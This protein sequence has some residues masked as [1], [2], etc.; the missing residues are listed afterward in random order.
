MRVAYV[1]NAVYPEITGRIE[2]RVWELAG[3]LLHGG[4]RYTYLECSFGTGIRPLSGKGFTFAERNRRF[5]P[6]L[7]FS[8][9]TF[10]FAV[11]MAKS[12]AV[13]CRD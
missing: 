6:S 7:M 1:Y 12:S 9:G 4:M 2:C 13:V 10:F 3:D 5:F 8:T 11:I